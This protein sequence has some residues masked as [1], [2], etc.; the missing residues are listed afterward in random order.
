[1]ASDTLSILIV[2]QTEIF[3]FLF[4]RIVDSIL[5]PMLSPFWLIIMFFFSSFLTIF[6]RN[7]GPGHFFSMHTQNK[8]K[9]KQIRLFIY[10]QNI[11]LPLIRHSQNIQ[12][13]IMALLILRFCFT[14]Y[15]CLP[16]CQQWVKATGQLWWSLPWAF[17]DSWRWTDMESKVIILILG[18][19]NRNPAV[20][21]GAGREDI[22]K[23][24]N[25]SPRPC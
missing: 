6:S 1:M 5:I 12:M 7:R 10:K 9:Y 15:R 8:N 11:Y 3:L 24:R 22:E 17:W 19:K 4:Q 23:L 2:I 13:C 20:R 14:N 21:A 18:I 25:R 16:E